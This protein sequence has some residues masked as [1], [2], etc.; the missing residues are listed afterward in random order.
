MKIFLRPALLSLLILFFGGTGCTS[1]APGAETV[2]VAKTSQDVAG[3]K[4]VGTVEGGAFADTR[5]KNETI[6]KGGDTLFI[7]NSGLWT[8]HNKSYGVAYNCKGADV[9][10]PVPV[11][12]KEDK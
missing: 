5:M 1:L 3:C 7:T 11:R 4:A 8:R 6:A 2:K 10:Q 9:R 12:G